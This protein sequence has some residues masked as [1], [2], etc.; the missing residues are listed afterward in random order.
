MEVCI[1]TGLRIGDALELRTAQIQGGGRVTV[2]E[3][4]TGK[5]RRI[6]IPAPLVRELRANAGR[7]WVFEGAWDPEKHRTRQAVWKDVKRAAKAAR[8]PANVGTHSARKVYAVQLYR[9]RGLGAA[10]AAL[11]HDDPVVTMVYALADAL[12]ARRGS[13]KVDRH[14]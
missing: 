8:I 9:K 12:R 14:S 1:S 11:N 13:K 10:Q 2:R 3:R 5:S 7:V 4:K 6:T